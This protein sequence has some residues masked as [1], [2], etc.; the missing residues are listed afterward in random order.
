MRPG[1]ILVAEHNGVYIIKLDGDVRL[2]L[3][4]SFDQFIQSM[5]SDEHF[6]SVL[7]DLKDAEAIDS[8][9]LGLMAKI[10]IIGREQYD[11]TP[12]IVSTNP[13]I[14]RLLDSMG[15]EAI[16]NIVEEAPRAAVDGAEPLQ[17]SASDDEVVK[18]K[19]LEAHKVLMELNETNRETFK[20]LV[21]TLESST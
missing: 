21:A 6:Y 13:S 16:F 1:R 15:F 18:A 17:L 8:T 5:F 14:N 9:T 4:I 7:F 20:D 2:T 3:C 11:I 19:V 10:A 12:M